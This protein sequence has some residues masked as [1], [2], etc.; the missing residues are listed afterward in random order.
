MYPIITFEDFK[1]YVG[2]HPNWHY[3]VEPIRDKQIIVA[4]EYFNTK[5]QKSGRKF[6]SFRNYNALYE[7][8]LGSNKR[9]RHLYEVIKGIELAK[10]RYDVDLMA[11]STESY[12]EQRKVILYRLIKAFQHV[13]NELTGQN[14]EYIVYS[15]CSAPK[16]SYHVILPTVIGYHYQLDEFYSQTITHLNKHYPLENEKLKYKNII[17]SSIYKSLQ[18]FRILYCCKAGKDRYKKILSSFDYNDISYKFNDRGDKDNFYDSLSGY[19]NRKDVLKLTFERKQINVEE[20][21]LDIDHAEIMAL[22]ENI[23][24]FTLREI[25]GGLIIL[26]KNAKHACPTCSVGEYKHVH[27]NENPYLHVSKYGDVWFDCRRNPD[28]KR[29]YLGTINTIDL[30]EIDVEELEDADEI[31]ESIES[32]TSGSPVV[33]VSTKESPPKSKSTKSNCNTVKYN[34]RDVI[35]HVFKV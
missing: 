4:L 33:E 7:F 34:Y 24:S 25:N 21:Q 35:K 11:D 26:T 29:T 14:C 16:V 10:M 5:K 13:H 22:V 23:G 12:N 27:D 17:D 18:N 32:A 3:K 8:V 28:K 19:I 30:S 1:S 9:F 6:G 31:V 2:N 20:T 15:S